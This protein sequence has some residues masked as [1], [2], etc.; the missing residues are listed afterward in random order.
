MIYV[1][2]HLNCDLLILDYMLEVLEITRNRKLGF[3]VLD[4][5]VWKNG[6]SPA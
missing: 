5:H 6:V 4:L 2:E 1:G 3:V